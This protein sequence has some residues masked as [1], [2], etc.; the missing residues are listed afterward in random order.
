[1]S[2]ASKISNSSQTQQ[3]L[4]TNKCTNK[5]TKEH[6]KSTFFATQYHPEFNFEVLSGM[7]H[8]RKTLL[9]EQGFYP[10]LAAAE[11]QACDFEHLHS[12]TPVAELVAKYKLTDSVLDIDQRQNEFKNWLSLLAL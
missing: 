1:M 4:S 6:K 11:T 12:P 10:D 5:C 9:V 8:S 2:E 3:T 7:T